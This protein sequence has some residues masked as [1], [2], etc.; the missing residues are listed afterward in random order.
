MVF[1]GL[2]LRALLS[3]DGFDKRDGWQTQGRRRARGKKVQQ[4]T[5]A[6][7]NNSPQKKPR[8]KQ[9]TLAVNDVNEK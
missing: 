5:L 8:A 4:R 1:S 7:N 2:L 9:D 6:V 3:R